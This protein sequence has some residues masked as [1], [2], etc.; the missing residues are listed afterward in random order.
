MLGL[1]LCIVWLVPLGAFLFRNAFCS[2]LVKHIQKGN[3]LYQICAMICIVGIVAWGGVKPNMSMDSNSIAQ[4][5]HVS[6]VNALDSTMGASGDTSFTDAELASGLVFLNGDTNSTFIATAPTNAIVNQKWVMTGA[7]EDFFFVSPTNWSFYINEK[8]YSNLFVSTT[9]N[10]AFDKP[11]TRTTAFTNQYSVLSPF[12]SV[13][14]VLPYHLWNELGTDKASRFWYATTEYNSLLLT[15]ENFLYLRNANY[16]IS[17]QAELFK[18]GEFEFRYDFSSLQSNP[19]NAFIGYQAGDIAN[20]YT[21]ITSQIKSIKAKRLDPSIA[22]NN[23]SDNDGLS[24]SDEVL[25]Y[26][27]DPTLADSDFDGMSDA[28]EITADNNPLNPDED[29]DGSRDYLT[30]ELSN[31]KGIV[32]STPSGASTVFVFDTVLPEGTYATLVIDNTTII[33][34]SSNCE[35]YLNLEASVLYDYELHVPKNVIPNFSFQYSSNFYTRRMSLKGSGSET[36]TASAS[37]E[38]DNIINTVWQVIY[39]IDKEPLKYKG[40]VADARIEFIHLPDSNLYPKEN[41]CLHGTEKFSARLRT[42]PSELLAKGNI[43]EIDNLVHEGNNIYTMYVDTI[44]QGNSDYGAVT[45]RCPESGERVTVYMNAH[46]CESITGRYCFGCGVY[47]QGVECRAHTGLCQVPFVQETNCT[48][49]IEFVEIMLGDI[50]ANGIEDRNE[51]LSSNIKSI[52]LIDNIER[53]CC[54]SNSR[55]EFRNV[56]CGYGLENKGSTS[57]GDSINV[58]GQNP[59]GEQGYTTISYDVYDTNVEKVNSITKKALVLGLDLMFDYNDDG[60]INSEDKQL[61]YYHSTSNYYVSAS[62]EILPIR[63]KAEIPPNLTAGCSSPNL[64]LFSDTNGEI[65]YE[66]PIALTNG[67]YNLY[68]QSS[69]TN[70]N[71]SINLGCHNYLEKTQNITFVDT[72]LTNLTARFGDAIELPYYGSEMINHISI[73]DKESSDLCEEFYSDGKWIVGIPQGEY[74]LVVYYDDIYRDGVKGF[75]EECTLIVMGSNSVAGD[76]GLKCGTNNLLRIDVMNEDNLPFDITWKISPA[77]PNGAKLSLSEDSSKAYQIQTNRSHLFVHSGTATNNYTISGWIGEHEVVP[78]T[79]ISVHVFPYEIDAPDQIVRSHSIKSAPIGVTTS[80]EYM[81][82]TWKLIKTMDVSSGSST[83]GNGF[84]GLTKNN[85]NDDLIVSST[86]YFKSHKAGEKYNLTATHELY[87]N[88][89]DTVE[90]RTCDIFFNP[91]SCEVI[92]D[93][94]VVNPRGFVYNDETHYKVE[95][96]PED[97]LHNDVAWVGTTPLMVTTRAPKNL[98]VGL[99]TAKGQGEYFDNEITIQIPDYYES[100]PKFTVR[101]YNGYKTIKIKPII[102]KYGD[103]QYI[104]HLET[105][106]N[107][108]NYVWY[109]KEDFGA[110]CLRNV[111]KGI[112]YANKI[113]RQAGIKFQVDTAIEKESH[114]FFFYKSSSV[115]VFTNLSSTNYDGI[116]LYIVDSFE[117]SSANGD[118]ANALTLHTE[119]EPRQFFGVIVNKYT[120]KDSYPHEFAHML[121]L[122][123]IYPLANIDLALDVYTKTE[124]PNDFTGEIN[125]YNQD[126]NR[127]NV[128]QNLVMYGIINNESENKNK[129]FSLSN[130]FGSVTNEDNPQTNHVKVGLK[131]LNDNVITYGEIINEN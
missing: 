99:N 90:L 36:Q 66:Q 35:I 120:L 123:D 80:S 39:T 15:W 70:A 72:S 89:T 103:N 30:P 38:E 67:V 122:Y 23:D 121:G 102:V 114:E 93:Y 112:S 1:L 54:A 29:G 61:Q 77:E 53:C 60:V 57:S 75:A 2:E 47:H 40:N 50:N 3:R 51:D 104:N 68:Y 88:V 128:I 69:L 34:L 14:G 84:I 92:G 98:Y 45:Y 6:N 64:N 100:P 16:P 101:V 115:S 55:S 17:Y 74:R 95:I 11:V 117:R 73:Y 21:N 71:T 63:I 94:Y 82:H 125:Y 13:Q 119:N 26:G 25:I 18:N 42:V 48:C 78:S 10:I 65:S 111:A 31:P 19:I 33:P 108:T 91:I 4:N 5:I 126:I 116:N 127:A 86:V 85:I 76:Y 81:N 97:F 83:S 43:V 113:Y 37:A 62:S 96:Y 105:S 58:V 59:S 107:P 9:G 106:R 87:T 131:N 52:M 118:V 49:E 124:V 24:D 22:N 32:V 79:D 8:T 27:T 46:I 20:Q 44:G 56:Q 41:P 129:I 12:R 110:T 7:A 28:A 109:S 130:V